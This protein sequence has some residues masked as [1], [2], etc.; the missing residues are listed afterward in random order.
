MLLVA[1]KRYLGAITG[2]LLDFFILSLRFVLRPYDVTITANLPFVHSFMQFQL[3]CVR[4][5]IFHSGEFF[6][7]LA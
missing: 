7:S 5:I 2:L 1:A 4:D 3:N 6:C